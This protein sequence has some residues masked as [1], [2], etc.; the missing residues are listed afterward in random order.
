MTYFLEEDKSIGLNPQAIITVHSA[1][2]DTSTSAGS[3]IT[4]SGS[5]ISYTPHI[6]ATNVVYEISFYVEALNKVSYQH[7]VLQQDINN[8]GS[9]TTIDTRLGKGFGALTAGNYVRD[10]MNSRF[11]I[12]AWAGLRPL[13]LRS[14]A[15]KV[16]HHVKYHQLTQWDGASSTTTFCNTS[17]LVYSV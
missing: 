3:Y 5:E 7:L 13:R 10:I 2:Q 6:S 11:I 17:L 12:P 15:H 14:A 4:I 9:W 1:A 8:N 16:N